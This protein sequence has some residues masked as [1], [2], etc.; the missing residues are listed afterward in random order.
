MILDSV[1][2]TESD[3]AA[4]L[5]G[6][7]RLAGIGDDTPLDVLCDAAM[8]LMVDGAPDLRKWR[9][10]VDIASWRIKPPDRASWGLRPDQVAAQQQL[11]G[12]ASK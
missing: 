12:Q 2:A 6:K 11:M 5:R 8:V 1:C 4:Y 10:Q 7:L 3:T 9:D